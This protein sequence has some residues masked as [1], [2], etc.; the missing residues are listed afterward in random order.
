M[1][2]AKYVKMYLVNCWMWLEIVC[3]W[4]NYCFI[5]L[6]N[7]PSINFIFRKWCNMIL[8]WLHWLIVGHI[9]MEAGSGAILRF[10]L[11]NFYKDENVK[12]ESE[13]EKYFH[14]AVSLLL[15]HLHLFAFSLC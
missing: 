4:A 2:I 9:G 13:N 1:I 15:L 5:E 14:F 6:I 12:R 11:F 3:D 8:L 10:L 7:V